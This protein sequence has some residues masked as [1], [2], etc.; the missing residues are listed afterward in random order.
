MAVLIP[1]R[2]ALNLYRQALRRSRLEPPVMHPGQG[3][4]SQSPSK[5][6]RE[7]WRHI[8]RLRP[9]KRSLD[10]RNAYLTIGGFGISE[11]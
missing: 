7:F 3:G 4:R 8:L 9:L 11:S 2:G 1:P 5:T 10:T 6:F